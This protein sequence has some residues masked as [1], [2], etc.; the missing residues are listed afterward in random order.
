M[1]PIISE[2]VDFVMKDELGPHLNDAVSSLGYPAA[3]GHAGSLLMWLRDNGRPTVF[4]SRVN[5]RMSADMSE[6]IRNVP[7]LSQLVTVSDQVLRFSYVLRFCS[8]VPPGEQADV[9]RQAYETFKP[10]VSVEWIVPPTSE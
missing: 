4:E 1:N 6:F 2:L 7:G 8:T 10:Q 3:K 5:R 9:A